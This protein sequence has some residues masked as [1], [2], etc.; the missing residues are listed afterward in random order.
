MEA[1]GTALIFQASS[2]SRGWGI[3]PWFRSALQ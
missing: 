3:S 1:T 2:C